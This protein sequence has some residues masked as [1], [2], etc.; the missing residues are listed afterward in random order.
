MNDLLREPER[1]PDFTLEF[2]QYAQ[3]SLQS[4][5][6]SVSAPGPLARAPILGQP[7]GG[8]YFP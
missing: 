3:Y 4:R 7:L 8:L 1:R 6:K 2:V 5:T